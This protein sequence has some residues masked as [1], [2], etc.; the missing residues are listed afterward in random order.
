MNFTSFSA[1]IFLIQASHEPTKAYYGV[2][3]K[4]YA[5][6]SCQASASLPFKTRIISF[7]TLLRKKTFIQPPYRFDRDLV[8]AYL[9]RDV[10]KALE[11]IK[12][13]A[14]INVSVDGCPLLIHAI[15][16]NRPTIALCL[17]ACGADVNKSSDA[18]LT[19][20][21]AAA[22]H[23]HIDIVGKLL[24]KGAKPNATRD[25][26]FTPLFFAAKAGHAPI[27]KMLLE[28][29]SNVLAVDDHQTTALM[30]AANMGHAD[31]VRELGPTSNLEARDD[32]GRTALIYAV[33]GGHLRI[34][35][36]L[37]A[38]GANVN[39]SD[40]DG[41][42]PLMTAAVASSVAILVTLLHAGADINAV[43]E[44]DQC[45]AL[46]FAAQY[47]ALPSVQVL[48]KKGAAIDTVNLQGE[49][50]IFKAAANSNIDIVNALLT[51]GANPNIVD[52]YEVSPLMATATSVSGET[53][54]LP[55]NP[56]LTALVQAG[57][58]VNYSIPSTGWTALMVA[59]VHQP[60]CS[61]EFH[62][63][64]LG[65]DMF[66]RDLEGNTAAMYAAVRGKWV[67][68]IVI[69]VYAKALELIGKST[70]ASES[71]LKTCSLVDKDKD[72]DTTDHMEVDKAAVQK[73]GLKRARTHTSLVDHYNKATADF[74]KKKKKQGVN[75]RVYGGDKRLSG[76]FVR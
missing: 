65:A 66:A 43:T 44:S 15:Q 42:T 76:I 60:T 4:P 14:N 72:K 18:F 26:G 12:H 21:M 48:L 68:S 75:S 46:I 24:S 17:I 5:S 64:A 53:V 74:K 30:Y 3:Q 9:S 16:T 34:V 23:G 47:N 49:A 8:D 63:I 27:C 40:N 36:G 70:A 10:H 67:P 25:E 38:V 69:A 2:Y 6:W 55:I 13:G 41:V 45:T 28:A 58:D 71:I 73:R 7:Q 39:A 52:S 1:T 33:D 61:A 19:P 62:L 22:Y 37:L 35:R 59:A 20:L 31:V 32:S 11:A 57:A 54:R 51:A 29:G 56:V 50:A